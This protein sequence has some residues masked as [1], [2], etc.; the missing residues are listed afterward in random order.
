MKSYHQTT[1]PIDYLGVQAAKLKKDSQH[2]N[3]ENLVGLGKSVNRQRLSAVMLS[4]L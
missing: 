1:P 4:V 3:E 2:G